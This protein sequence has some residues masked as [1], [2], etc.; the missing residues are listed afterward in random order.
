MAVSAHEVGHALQDADG[1]GPLELRT[2]LFPVAQAA[3]RFGVP[4][5]LFG[6]FSGMPWLVQAG[7]LAYMGSILM[8]FLTLPV[9]YDASRR[10]IAQLNRLGMMRGDE[11]ES[12]KKTL[13]AAAMTYVASVAS[14]AGFIVFFGIGR[15]SVAHRKAR[16]AT[17]LR[18]EES[19]WTENSE[20]ERN[21]PSTT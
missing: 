8:H 19:R 1:Y 12:A 9:E 13:K 15:P 2:A 14:A 4:V 5:A 10:A 16:A 6:A 11:E 17:G 3:S 20:H 21:S 7:M 18:K